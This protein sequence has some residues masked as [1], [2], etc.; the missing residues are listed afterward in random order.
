MFEKQSYP[1]SSPSLPKSTMSASALAGRES[2]PGVNRG[3]VA[4]DADRRDGRIAYVRRTLLPGVRTRPTLPPFAPH[5]NAAGNNS[6]TGV[7]TLS[8]FP[9]SYYYRSNPH[10]HQLQLSQTPRGE[11]S[12][13]CGGPEFRQFEEI[14]EFLS[15]TIQGSFR[16]FRISQF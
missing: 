14:F 6:A 12:R 8:R 5:Y 15:F 2:N 16:A 3:L 4:P 13:V 7:R 1:K 10:H 9:R 11:R